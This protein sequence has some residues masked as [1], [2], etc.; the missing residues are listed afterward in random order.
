MNTLRSILVLLLLVSPSMAANELRALVA[1]SSTGNYLLV[2]NPDNPGQA[3]DTNA[4]DWAT[5]DRTDADQQISIG[6][7]IAAGASDEWQYADLPAG[8]TATSSYAFDVFDSDD[9]LLAVGATEQY[10]SHSA[11]GTPANLGSGPTLA[12]NN[13]DINDAAESASSAVNNGPV[14]FVPVSPN[15]TLKVNR[16]GSITPITSRE[17]KAGE[18][19]AVQFDFS[20]VLNRNTLTSMPEPT[21]DDANTT[22]PAYGINGLGDGGKG[23][24]V[25]LD[26][27]AATAGETPTITATVVAGTLTYKASQT[28]TIVE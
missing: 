3:W 11:V 20:S 12:Q 8:L 7:G 14:N 23:G 5:Y 9:E 18:V 10:A 21:S 26:C 17:I 2:R 25:I 4:G 13:E 22:I 19:V 28:F 24:N 1:A 15:Y 16:D 27:T 6:S